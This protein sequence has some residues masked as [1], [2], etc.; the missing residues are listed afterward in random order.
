MPRCGLP[1]FCERYKIDTGIYDPKSKK[2]SPGMLNKRIYV[3]A[4]IKTFL[5][6]FGKKTEK[7]LYLMG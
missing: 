2:N 7:M 3:G 6:L 1:E 5:V 4:F